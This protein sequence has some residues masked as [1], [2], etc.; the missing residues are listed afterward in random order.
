MNGLDYIDR[1]KRLIDELNPPDES[2]L[3]TASRD[4]R[5]ARAAVAELMEA[6]KAHRDSVT[7]AQEKECAARM[8]AALAK[9][10]VA[11]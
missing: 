10:E 2:P 9:L 11:K 7:I 3:T 4:L 8:Y 5:A 6:V 1:A